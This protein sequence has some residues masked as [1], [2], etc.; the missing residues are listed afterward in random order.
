MNFEISIY[1]K[2]DVYIESDDELLE[3][4]FQNILGNALKHGKRNLAIT[5][6]EDDQEVVLRVENESQKAVQKIHLLTSRFYSENMST[7]EESSGLG[8]YIVDELTLLTNGTL[9]LNYV[10][11]N[12]SIELRWKKVNAIHVY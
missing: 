2:E 11:P 1:I 8:L 5:L 7:T 3:R 9:V 12:F 4:I 10:N 6:I